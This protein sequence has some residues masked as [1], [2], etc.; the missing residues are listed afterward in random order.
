MLAT[1]QKALKEYLHE[2]KDHK[3]VN[4]RVDEQGNTFLY[5][6]YPPQLLEKIVADDLN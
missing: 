3:I 2:A 4:E 6:Q 1:S 5:M